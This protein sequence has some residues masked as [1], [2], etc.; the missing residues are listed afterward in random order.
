MNW[1]KDR[2]NWVGLISINIRKLTHK[3][4]ICLVWLSINSIE[5]RLVLPAVRLCR[6]LLKGFINRTIVTYRLA[7][8]A[9]VI[10]CLTDRWVSDRIRKKPWRV[11]RKLCLAIPT[12]ISSRLNAQ[13]IASMM[14]PNT[15][16]DSLTQSALKMLWMHSL[17]MFKSWSRS[18]VAQ[19]PM[20]SSVAITASPFALMLT[21]F[22]MSLDITSN[23]K[24]VPTQP[25]WP[26]MEISVNLSDISIASKP[27]SD[28]L[29]NT[30]LYAPKRSIFHKMILSHPWRA[31][32]RWIIVT[33][34]SNCAGWICP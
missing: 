34:W 23:A 22:T 7:Q 6:W 27:A 11:F 21:N 5:F 18:I 13:P 33:I 12:H 25:K 15:V 19:H 29:K 20:R 3:L 31:A 9:R 2:V 16:F 30:K 32:C 24:G 14:R 4:Q 28:A 1:S 26:T 17:A 10:T 8:L